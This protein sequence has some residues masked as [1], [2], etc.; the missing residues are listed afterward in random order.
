MDNNRNF[1]KRYCDVNTE[2]RAPAL[3]P[4]HAMTSPTRRGHES[5]SQ[6][7]LERYLKKLKSKK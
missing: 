1:E 3:L 4:Y 2:N 6:G 7:F 5:D